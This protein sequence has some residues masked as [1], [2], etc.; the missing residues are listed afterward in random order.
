MRALGGPGPP[1]ARTGGEVF[2]GNNPLAPLAPRPAGNNPFTA[3][4]L[5]PPTTGFRAPVLRAAGNNPPRAPV[6][7][8]AGNNPPRAPVL[9]AAGNNPF[10]ANFEQEEDEQQDQ[11]VDDMDVVENNLPASPYATAAAPPVGKPSRG[12]GKSPPAG[13]GTGVASAGVSPVRVPLHT[14][15]LVSGVLRGP[16]QELK[17]NDKEQE[18]ASFLSLKTPSEDVGQELFRKIV[19][20]AVVH[21]GMLFEN[22]ARITKTD[23]A[24]LFTPD[25][26]WRE[27][28][29]TIA[30]GMRQFTVLQELSMGC[31]RVKTV[32]VA[33]VVLV[34]QQHS[35]PKFFQ[36]ILTRGQRHDYTT[37]KIQR[38]TKCFVGFLE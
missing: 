28:P 23:L 33:H 1:N 11:F 25:A 14:G 18:L 5:D 13:K 4:N 20:Q 35:R 36:Q 24:D 30:E 21:L 10:T 17:L 9:R 27:T 12:K 34:L 22:P 2:A 19:D 29:D 38:N 8:A 3:N 26:V 16:A 6:L 31:F 37:P 7:R 15:P 32:R